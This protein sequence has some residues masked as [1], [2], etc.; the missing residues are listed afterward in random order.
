MRK[1]TEYGP[2]LVVLVTAGLVLLLGPFLVREFTYRQTRVR[3]IEARDQLERATILDELNQSYRAI[4]EVVEPSVVHISATQIGPGGQPGLSTGSGWVYDADGHIVTNHHVVTDVDRIDVQLSNGTTRAAEVVGYDASTDIAVLRISNERLHPA[5]LADLADPVEQGD[6]VFAFGSPFDFRFSMSSGIVSGKGRQVGVIRDRSGQPG[7]ENFIQVDAAINPGNSGGPLTDHRG[8][9]IGMNTAIATSSSRRGSFED[10]QFAGIGLAIP[11]EMIVP[12]VNQIIEKGFVA[13]GFLGV[14][15]DNLTPTD[16]QRLGFEG[17]GA[18][19]SGVEDGTPAARAG[20]EAGDIV[21]HV[22]GRPVASRPQLQSVVS[23]IPPGETVMLDVVRYDADARSSQMLTLTVT[24]GRLNS[25][26]IRGEIPPDQP[27]SHLLALGVSAMR[28]ATE[29][30]A[31]EYETNFYEGVVIDRVVA[32]SYLDG[33]IPPGTTIVEVNDVPISNAD[34]LI[35]ELRKYDV[36]PLPTPFGR[37]T[38][39]GV[40]VTIFRPG[41]NAPATVRMYAQ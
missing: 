11:L 19:I 27:R 35:E 24:L 13:K 33:R 34:E 6:L 40:L 7:Y 3:I 31:R 38:A 2:S 23:S 39:G 32:G 8:R 25:T 12:T 41:T 20:L 17:D 29:A 30:I 10:G 36:R 16:R 18:L 26:Q 21:T 15:V 22:D 9:V 14:R 37:R 5:E 1:L 4:G 28:D